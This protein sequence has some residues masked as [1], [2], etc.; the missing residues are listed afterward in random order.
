MPVD[1]LSEPWRVILFSSLVHDA[2]RIIPDKTPDL[3]RFLF[4]FGKRNLVVTDHSSLFLSESK[5][6]SGELMF[7]SNH[8]PA[9]LQPIKPLQKKRFCRPVSTLA[10][11]LSFDC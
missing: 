4:C 9:L 2:D 1:S 3:N 5:K 10:R 11:R 7:D 8:R 6:E